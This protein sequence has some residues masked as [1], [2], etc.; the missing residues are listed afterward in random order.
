MSL[1][2]SASQQLNLAVKH[3]TASLG[4]YLEQEQR[5]VSALL[6]PRQLEPL[7]P[8][9]YRY[10]VSP[11]QVFQ[12]RIQPVVDLQTRLQD[13]R[14]ELQA[15][16]CQLEGLGLVDDFVLNL[17]SWLRATPQGLE[18]EATLSV[19][20]SQPPL[21]RLIPAGV[22]EATG[23]SLLAGILIGIKGR[24]GAQLLSDFEQWLQQRSTAAAV[25]A[26]AP[27]ENCAGAGG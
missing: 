11:L 21:L 15:S 4:A 9:H 3:N 7:A 12:L 2:F 14:L 1:A 22:L 17:S 10:T 27:P 25:P 23:H 6:D 26:P 5:V 8:G 13:G 24:V 19:A 18:G 20:V 16:D